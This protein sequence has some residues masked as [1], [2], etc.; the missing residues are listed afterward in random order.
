MGHYDPH[1]GFVYRPQ[2]N[3]A[4]RAT[5]GSSIDIPYASLVSGLQTVTQTT[6][7]I[8][9]TQPNPSLLPEIMVDQELGADYRFR[10]GQVISL[11]LYNDI[12]HNPWVTVNALLPAP[13]AGFASGTTYYQS[14]TF[15]EANRQGKGVEFGV[16]NLPA[17]GFGYSLSGDLQRLF[18]YN[19]DNQYLATGTKDYNH[20]AD[21]G[22][23]YSK[24]YLNLQYAGDGSN[25]LNLVRFGIDYEGPGNAA[26]YLSYFVYDAGIRLGLPQG[27]IFQTSIENVTNNQ[28]GSPGGHAI[29][30][31]GL[32]PVQ[33]QYVNGQYVYQQGPLRGIVVP[34]PVTVRFSL[35][36]KL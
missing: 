1:F 2:P 25:L 14:S 34:L 6:S 30:T 15:N 4:I 29:A 10:N 11:A 33:L 20:A 3:L 26:N 7:S 27:V 19:L 36:K 31:Q 22:E 32:N 18:Y 35:V 8:T 13:P 28:F 9:I 21:F 17:S 24:G 5:Y 23:P 16:A 12:V